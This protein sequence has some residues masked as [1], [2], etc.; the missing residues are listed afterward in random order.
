LALAVDR[1][2]GL[3]LFHRLYPANEHDS[4]VFSGILESVYGQI[5]QIVSDK[6][7][8]T[9][10]FDKG[11]N[12]HE[13]IESLDESRHH[14]I[15]SRSPFHH[16]DLCRRPLSDFREIK[17]NDDQSVLALETKEELY[18]QP[19]RVILTYNE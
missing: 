6:K 12:S 11:N 5:S 10:I 19:R 15:G 14:F 1:D 16:K 8:L 3:P 13:A 2:H 7:A 4:K 17:L 18:G 9:L